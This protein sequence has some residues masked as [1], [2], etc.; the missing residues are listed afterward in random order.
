VTKMTG[1]D[2]TE[3]E[4]AE[5]EVAEYERW[6]SEHP[7]AAGTDASDLAAIGA[8]RRASGITRRQVTKLVQTAL[9]RGRSWTEIADRL[10]M[11][12]T[13]AKESYGTDAPSTSKSEQQQP[14]TVVSA[15]LELVANVLG[16]AS[17]AL[18]AAENVAREHS[19]H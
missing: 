10:G 15:L 7:D 14:R 16:A 1:R 2:L 4:I 9:A 17:D 11:T 12:V 18:S 13:Q 8:A 19:R 3:R 5:S 6:A